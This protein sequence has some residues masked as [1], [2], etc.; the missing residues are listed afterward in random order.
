[1]A[2]N[3]MAHSVSEMRKIA[4]AMQQ[5]LDVLAVVPRSF[6]GLSAAGSIGSWDVATAMGTNVD[7]A[8]Q[9]MIKCVATF[10]D[11]YEGLIKAINAATKNYS[12]NETGARQRHED[13]GEGLVPQPT[14]ASQN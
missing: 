14:Q 10:L 9:T 8:H 3:E 1:M 11:S 5:E 13:V 6:G 2:S 12:L 7:D 4:R